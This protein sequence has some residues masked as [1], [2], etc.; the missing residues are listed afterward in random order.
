M[1]F[2]QCDFCEHDFI[3]GTGHM[4]WCQDCSEKHPM[5]N[6]CFVENLKNG[7]IKV[8]PANRNHISEVNLKRMI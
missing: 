4:C 6:D 7:S 1:E 8:T 3:S 5:C 2:V